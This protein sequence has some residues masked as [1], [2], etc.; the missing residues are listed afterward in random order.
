MVWRPAQRWGVGCALAYAL[1]CPALALGGTVV[2]DVADGTLL[3]QV[4]GASHLETRLAASL[5]LVHVIDQAFQAGALRPATVVAVVQGPGTDRPLPETT[6]LTADELLLLLLLTGDRTAAHSLALSV[7]QS[8]GAMRTRMLAAASRLGLTATSEPPTPDEA[9]A[10]DGALRT[11][12]RDLAQLGLALT[13]T[14]DIR[15]RL[16]LDG[17]PIANGQFIVR[18]TNPLIARGRR[19]GS[20]RAAL[21]LERRNDLELLAVATG[22]DA[23]TTAWETL[24]NALD[25]YERQVIVHSGQEVG[26]P[27]HVR[28]G[29]IPRFT[30]VA[31]ERFA[32]TARRDAAPRVATRLQLPTHVDAPVDVSQTVGEL[33]IEQQGE[34]VAVVPLVAPRTIAPRRWLGASFR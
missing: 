31:A 20:A 17:A 10:V 14:P 7:E 24:S 21:T 32:I 34:V 22:A 27:V 15:A 5:L 9:L 28:G 19:K 33:V 1:T 6:H 30:A 18:A 29:I 26:P 13:Q 11:S 12:G 23:Y 3:R 8:I 4:D 2:A 16:D 25:R